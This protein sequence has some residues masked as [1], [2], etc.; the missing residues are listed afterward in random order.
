MAAIVA[1]VKNMLLNHK[2][3]DTNQTLMV[4]FNAFNASSLDFLSTL[5]LRLPN[6][7]STMALNKM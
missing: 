2:D 1:D 6:G 7:L 3:I 4:S 5:L